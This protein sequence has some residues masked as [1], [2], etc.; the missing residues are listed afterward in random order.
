MTSRDAAAQEPSHAGEH[1]E[2]PTFRQLF[3]A[4]ISYVWRLLRR[5]GVA[6]RDLEDEAHEIFVVVHRHLAEYDPKRP[7]RTWLLGICYRRA[8]DY[9]RF[10]RHS[11]EVFEDRPD[12]P[13]SERTI[14]DR[15][16]EREAW[17]RLMASLDELDPE[18][19][20]ALVLHDLEGLSLQEIADVTGTPLQTVYSRIRSA[21]ES[22]VKRLREPVERGGKP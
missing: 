15:Y 22:L 16:A 20:M 17:T 12:A 13:A 2:T 7:F 10:A 11:R 4:N 14:E 1:A 18:R 6:E 8:S 21:R 9:R 19:R 5:L 3:D